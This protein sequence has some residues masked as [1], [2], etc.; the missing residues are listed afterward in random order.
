MTHGRHRDGT[1][2]RRPRAGARTAARCAAIG[3][4]SNRLLLVGIAFEIAM[5][6]LARLHPGARRHL[7]HERPLPRGTGSFLLA[8]PPLVL[9][10]E[11]ARKAVAR[12][13]RNAADEHARA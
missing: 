11:E 8:W 6:A 7:P 9:G 2:R 10:A 1:G 12:R 13:T 3:L 4:L 5:I